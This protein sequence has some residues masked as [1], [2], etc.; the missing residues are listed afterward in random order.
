MYEAKILK[1]QIFDESNTTTGTV[2]PH[3]FVH[4]KGWKQTWDEW[5]AGD[6]MLKLTEENLIKQKEMNAKAKPA[7]SQ[8]HKKGDSS[9]HHGHSHSH[10]ASGN[11]ASGS[12]TSG[13]AGTTTG[14]RKEAGRKRGRDEDDSVK[15]P[16]M[17][18]D[19]PDAL[20][21]VLV[22]DWEA[23]TKNN[24]LVSLPREPNVVDILAE[25]QQHCENLTDK[26]L[27]AQDTVLST[28]IAGL[29]LY[30]ER[31]LGSTLLYRFERGQYAEVRRKYVTGQHVVIGEEKSMSQVY[32]AEHLLR[33]IVNLPKMIAQTSLDSESVAI[34]REYTG[35]LTQFMLDNKTRL[36]LTEYENAPAHYLITMRA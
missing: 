23:V 9:S 14:R 29:Q 24:Q 33:L 20:K 18:L 28:Y 12:G 32:G 25:F 10:S 26:H 11:M 30:F 17:K 4:Y 34:L 5:V 35:E 7:P 8:S 2:G 21:V 22:D 19:I 13:G 27:T 1:A 6:R 15:K 31:S 36:F 3:Y 16:D